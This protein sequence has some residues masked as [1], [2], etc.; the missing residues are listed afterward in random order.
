MLELSSKFETVQ[1]YHSVIVVLSTPRRASS[2]EFQVDISKALQDLPAVNNIS[3][4][5]LAFAFTL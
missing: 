4:G 3:A 5:Y 2:R 1:W